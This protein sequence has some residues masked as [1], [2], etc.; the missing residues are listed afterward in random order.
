MASHHTPPVS[1]VLPRTRYTRSPSNPTT[2]DDNLRFSHSHYRRA[3]P[4]APSN[5]SRAFFNINEMAAS[6][7][8]EKSQPEPAHD[9]EP[10][11]VDTS[12]PTRSLLS[13]STDLESQSPTANE[14]RTSVPLSLAAEYDVA[15]RTKLLY[16]A[17]Y[18]TLNLLLTIY[19]KAVLG[20]FAFPWLLTVVHA[21]F[22]SVGTAMLLAYGT[23]TLSDLGLREN[24]VLIAFSFL[25]TIN[26]A[27][28]NVSLA[29]VSVPFHQIM[30]S[31]CPVFTI[32]LYRLVYSRDYSMATYLS[33]VPTII[34]VGLATYGDYYFT[35]IGF[36]LTLLGV[37]LASVKT[38]VSNRL[39]TGS[40]KLPAM[41]ILLRMS[42][43]AALQGLLYARATGEIGR[44]QIFVQEGH[45]PLT[46]ILAVAGNGFLAFVL[47]VS[48][49]QTNKLA[50]ALT[51]TV[52]G[53]LK[54]CLTILL[55]IVLFD[56]QV[57]L[58]NGVGMFI[59]VLGG[60]WYS[61]VE[62]DSKGK[63]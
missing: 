4:R 31:T 48:S 17:A 54:Q 39:M 51:L 43:L 32:L 24:L 1:V 50:G 29:A 60:A 18:F 15:T 22:V 63:K 53:N 38:V 25:F 56:V 35:S 27:I 33:L 30:R 13:T 6:P 28:S 52:A 3:Y 36:F 55:G 26:I 58:F 40:L 46:L 19:N 23:F 61:K 11:T 49:F 62:L 7:I 47:N 12:D 57:S 45:L 44:F 8:L 42:P 37:V 5:G 20:H 14:K 2:P 10:S 41:E 16:L 9:Y 59:A 21:T 34:G